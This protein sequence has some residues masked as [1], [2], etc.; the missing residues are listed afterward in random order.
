M[1]GVH[2]SRPD[3]LNLSLEDEDKTCFWEW[4]EYY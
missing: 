3:Q 4:N 2:K 1:N